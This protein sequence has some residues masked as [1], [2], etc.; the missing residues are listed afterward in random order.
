MGEL[1]KGTNK[2]YG[3]KRGGKRNEGHYNEVLPYILCLQIMIN[4]NLAVSNKTEKQL[5]KK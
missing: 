1:E 2:I 5:K 4:E 3:S